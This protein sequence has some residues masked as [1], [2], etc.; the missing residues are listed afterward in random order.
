MLWDANQNLRIASL[1][2][3]DNLSTQILQT[4]GKGPYQET[5]NIVTQPD[6]DQGQ[7]YGALKALFDQTKKLYTAE[8]FL[9]AEELKLDTAEQRAIVRKV[10]MA[11]F[12]S[13]VFG[14]QEVGFFHLNECFLDTFV[15]DGGR[16]LKSQGA[17]YLDLKTQ[18]YISAMST[19]ERPR[20]DILADLFPDDME[21]QL[22]A[23]RP[24]TKSL[25]PSEL[26][27]CSRA[28]KRKQHL[29]DLPP[30]TPLSEKYVWQDFLKDVSYYVCKNYEQ[31]LSQHNQQMQ[32]QQH[33]IQSPTMQ[34]QEDVDAVTAAA[35]T[36]HNAA[37]TAAQQAQLQH[38]GH[39][40][41]HIQHMQL[42]NDFLQQ[43]QGQ[44]PE[45]P[46]SFGAPPVAQPP[47]IQSAP[48]A[49]LYERARLAATAKS[50]SNARRAGLPSQRRPWTAEEE[51]ALMAGLDRVKGPHW[52]QILSM[53]GPG[54]TVNEVLKDRNQV[55][56][57]DKARNLKL[58][59]LKTGIEVPY[60]LQFVT[61]ELKTRAPG[62]A[63]KN[64][65]KAQQQAEAQDP[66]T[67]HMNAM[68][69]L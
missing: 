56:L 55:Q 69:A 31:L 16:L 11:T 36:A 52:S 61:G 38:P 35:L 64:A 66:H 45:V 32:Q 15:P 51:N 12:V 59:F 42:E 23:R 21:D 58:F 50:S 65:Q 18:A 26:D 3:L 41:P 30:E 49:V 68:N 63:L 25:T 62:Q 27:F 54:G 43:H 5:L 17:L 28:Q 7:A 46:V 8:A 20:E 19:N 34:T 2:I 13:S 24:G 22:K 53:F 44:A 33:T 60:Y 57:K 37:H 29:L 39:V 1:P 47:M 6:S 40:E 10:N 67:Q 48:T 14:S 4:L 9:A